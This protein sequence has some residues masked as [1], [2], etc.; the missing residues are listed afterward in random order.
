VI[1]DSKKY[2]FLHGF[3][4]PPPRIG[5][6]FQLHPFCQSSIRTAVSYYLGIRDDCTFILSRGGYLR[7]TGQASY[8]T[9]I[10]PL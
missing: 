5:G 7:I 9:T 1:L 4:N 6:G 10:T 8:Y 2:T 3:F